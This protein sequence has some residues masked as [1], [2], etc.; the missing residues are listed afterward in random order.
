MRGLWEVW[1]TIVLADLDLRRTGA[2]SDAIEDELREEFG[3]LFS[4]DR[5]GSFLTELGVDSNSSVARY[6]QRLM[7]SAGVR[8]RREFA[9][10]KDLIDAFRTRNLSLIKS[11]GDEHVRQLQTTLAT[12]QN[13]GAPVDTIRNAIV[14][15]LNIGGRRAMLIARDQTNKLNAELQ[16]TQQQ[17]AGITKFVWS[18]SH[19]EA[20]R[21]SHR[22]LDGRTF[23]YANPPIVDG[24]PALPGEPIQCRCQALPV[25][26]LFAG[27]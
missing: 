3:K 20:V 8:V 24:E 23:E 12:L 1:R 15:R 21:D 6:V 26:D 14:E 19:D 17:A 13:E 18:T 25:I 27:I 11:L 16:A 4:R 2:R 9:P 7:T 5:L 10:P 22:A